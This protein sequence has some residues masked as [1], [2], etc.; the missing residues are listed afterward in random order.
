M[1][2]SILMFKI[3]Y[4]CWSQLMPLFFYVFAE[5]AN[6]YV[7]NKL[8]FVMGTT[9]GDRDAL[10][11]DVKDSGVYA[12][13]APNMGKQIVAFQTMME[14]MAEKFPGCFSGY[15]LKVVE[16]HQ[17]SKVDTSGTAKAVVGSFQKMG[18]DFAEVSEKT[19][20]VTF[21]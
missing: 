19:L 14:T 13:I 15:T 7:K 21:I 11:R 9:G 6:F 1:F 5:N 18:L 4:I 16:S 3:V 8:P 17:R 10:I 12:V 20:K 2:L